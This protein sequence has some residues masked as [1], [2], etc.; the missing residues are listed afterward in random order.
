MI[1]SQTPLRI[2]IAGGGTDLPAFYEREDGYV[3]NAAID[4][5][6]FVVLNER[7]DDKI[8]LNYSRKEII[9]HVGE[10]LLKGWQY[11]RK[12]AEKISNSEIDLM[13]NKA[14]SAGATGGKITGAGG[15]GFLLLY[16]PKDRRKSVRKAL[17]GYSELP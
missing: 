2:G 5:F 8:Y 15:G 7:F 1:I 4:K 13:I 16:V 9:D 11:K 14:I 10:I 6:V 3:L 12:M 17:K